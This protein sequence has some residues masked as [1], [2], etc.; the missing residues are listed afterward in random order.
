MS[1]GNLSLERGR[2]I[3]N[4][5][6]MIVAKIHLRR[7]RL[8]YLLIPRYHGTEEDE[9]NQG[10]STIANR[11]KD[12]NIVIVAITL[13]YTVRRSDTR[14]KSPKE[15]TIAIARSRMMGIGGANDT[16]THL[17]Y[18]ILHRTWI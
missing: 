14:T 9:T 7:H 16:T 6:K 3:I 18:P 5:V 10:G 15:I 4:Q 12:Q 11:V 13:H 1:M 2:S 8:P 17:Y